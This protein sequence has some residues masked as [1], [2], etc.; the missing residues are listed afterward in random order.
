MAPVRAKPEHTE[1]C[2]SDASNTGYGGF[3]ISLA[4]RPIS[5]RWKPKETEKSSA[6]RELTA[7]HRVMMGLGGA[8]HGQTI[9]WCTDN[10]SVASIL[11]YGSRKADLQAIAVQ[12]CEVLHEGDMIVIPEWVP[13]EQNTLADSIAKRL[14]RDDWALEEKHFQRLNA[15]WGPPSV[16][17]FASEHTAKCARFN[18]K[19]WAKH[20]EATDAFSQCW[21]FDSNWLCP[22]LT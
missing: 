9:K 13:R 2:F 3:R 12:I 14:N 22:R 5:G 6:W 4:G 19:Y 20:A 7:V 8:L 16:D 15:L 17:R 18:T 1:V 11:R 21:A 10:S